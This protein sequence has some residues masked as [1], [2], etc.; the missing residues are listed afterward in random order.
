MPSFAPH[1]PEEIERML[2][3][4]GLGRLEDLYE[5]IPSALLL[6]RPLA[7]PRG[8]S[9]A[10]ILDLMTSFASDNAPTR[11]QLVSFAGGGAYDHDL[12]SAA[13]A[14]GQQASF[15]TSYTPYQPEVAQGVLQALFEF[16]TLVARLFGVSVA[17]ASLYD[18]AASLVE[19]ANLAVGA[20]KRRRVLVSL[21]VN[22]RYRQALATFGAGSGLALEWLALRDDDTTVLAAS[23]AD[24]AA[25]V[26]GYPNF[27]GA[28][29]PLEEAVAFARARHAL[30]VVVA[31]P[32]ALGLVRSPGSY[33]ADVVV[34]EGQSLGLPLSFGGPYL[35]LFGVRREHLR[36]VP[37]RLVGETVDLE[38]RRAF[39]TTLRTRE[40]DIR[41]ERATSNV[42]TNQT[43]MA[44]QAAIHLAWLG[45]EGFAEV[46]RRSFDGAHYLAD[47]LTALGYPPRAQRFVREFTISLGR[48]AS[49]VVD[50]LADHGFLAGVVPPEHPDRLVVAATE[51]RTKEQ[52]DSFVDAFAKEVK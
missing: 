24:A 36:L 45:K 6:S 30:L 37:G 22:P 35:G 17:N 46:A 5:V 38:G 9:E 47:R 50:A 15:V 42:C 11:R 7:L 26:V 33:G 21:G 44:I 16:Q 2:A 39:V 25:V 12:S 41:R 52:I 8:A 31:D 4:L 19:A 32:I 48:K 43:L 10:E 28:L 51:A 49:G 1:T 14:L 18:G 13:R 23:D 27:Y 34:A 20:T 3:D 29:E 40:Q